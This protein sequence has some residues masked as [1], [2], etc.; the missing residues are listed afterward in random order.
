MRILRLVE[1]CIKSTG[2]RAGFFLLLFTLQFVHMDAG[3]YWRNPLAYFRS[4]DFYYTFIISVYVGL[5]RFAFPL[6]AILPAGLLYI[7]DWTS[8]FLV[9]ALHRQS[10]RRYVADRMIGS[11]L[12]AGLMVCGALTVTTVFYLL[13][14]PLSYQ[15]DS[16]QQ[17]AMAG[18]YGWRATPEFF[19]VFV[20]EVAGRLT[21]SAIFWTWIALAFSGICPNKVI[22]MTATLIFAYAIETIQMNNGLKEWT[23]SFVQ[24]PDIDTETPLWIP[25]VKQAGYILAA[26]VCCWTFLR[27]AASARIRRRV[28]ALHDAVDRAFHRMMPEQQLFM[29]RRFMGKPAGRLWAECRVFL[30]ASTVAA[31][32]VVALLCACLSPV[33]S[34]KKFSIGELLLSTFGGISWFEPEIDYYAIG[35]WVLLLLPP[36]MGIGDSM[37]REWKIRKPLTLYR[38]ADA[39]RWWHSRAIA[40]LLLPVFIVGLMMV[41]VILVGLL[42]GARGFVIYITDADG[43]AVAG[44]GVLLTMVLQFGLQVLL[45]TQLQ[46]LFHALFRDAKAGMTAYLGF[47]LVQ[48]TACSNIEQIRN[49]WMPA[50]WGMIARTKI[51]CISGYAYG[52]GLWMNLCAIE[53]ANAVTAQLL[54]IFVLYSLNRIIVPHTCTMERQRHDPLF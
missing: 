45:L 46:I 31:A 19:W 10:P 29:P 49:M 6:C 9:S 18:A 27:C 41:V 54:V 42:V 5:V 12:S 33:F 34:M 2:F 35:K 22:V 20:L 51:F 11:A 15:G 3:L 8:G 1:R 40:G 50:N 16:F 43:F 24:A 17:A 28:Q 52:E 32:S 25:L 44:Q 39:R 47:L 4:G 37:E 53:P 14:C 23:V 21:L 7:E 26:G 36:M 30:T 13:V 48:L 38:Y